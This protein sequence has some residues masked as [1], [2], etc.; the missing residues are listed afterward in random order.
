MAPAVK[1]IVIIGGTGQVGGSILSAL[2]DA[3]HF[4]ITCIT[5]P[6]S[7]SKLPDGVKVAKGEYDDKK[8][9]EDTLKGQDALIVALGLSAPPKVQEDLIEVAAKVELPW[10]MTNYWS[11]DGHN[12]ELV[13]AMPTLQEK[14]KFHL[15]LIHI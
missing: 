9:L 11:S 4:S 12:E 5:R 10:I 1:N 13:K 3:K 14:N 8:F 7:K 15:S 6:D 2:L